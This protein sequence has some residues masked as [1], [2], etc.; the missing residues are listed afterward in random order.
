MLS[1]YIDNLKRAVEV[2]HGCKC[3]YENSELVHERRN[4]QTVWR[5][6]VETYV[7]NG[8]PTATKAFAW[9][10]RN[11]VGEMSHAAILNISPVN[12]ARKAILA[13]LAG[14]QLC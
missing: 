10:W 11:D 6:M 5:G 7:L 1:V 14:E 9:G 3:S 8:H 13:A 2:M 12:S 4:G